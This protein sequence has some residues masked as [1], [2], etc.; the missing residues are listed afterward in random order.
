MKRTGLN[1]LFEGMTGIMIYTLMSV[2]PYPCG[3]TDTDKVGRCGYDG[4]YVNP[5]YKLHRSNTLLFSLF[6]CVMGLW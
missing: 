6:V 4:C 2:P 1:L 5:H 3:N